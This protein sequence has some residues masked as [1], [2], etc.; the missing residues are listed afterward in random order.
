MG[1]SQLDNAFIRGFTEEDAILSLV[2]PDLN[3]CT[4]NLFDY[5]KRWSQL[6]GAHQWRLLFQSKVNHGIYHECNPCRSSNHKP[7]NL[8]SILLCH[9]QNAQ[10]LVPSVIRLTIV[11]HSEQSAAW[12][13]NLKAREQRRVERSGQGNQA[14]KNSIHN[15]ICRRPLPDRNLTHQHQQRFKHLA[16][17]H[18]HLRRQHRLDNGAG[19][20][21]QRCY[22]EQWEEQHN[23]WD[24]RRA[25][26]SRANACLGEWNAKRDI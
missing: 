2:W 3:L 24:Y 21:D 25:D 4:S 12:N 19:F 20:S 18:P 11:Y 9:Q 14:D 6:L 23:C 16:L 15:D 26:V 22:R 7:L 10:R 17:F 1:S 8:L 13:R 5:I